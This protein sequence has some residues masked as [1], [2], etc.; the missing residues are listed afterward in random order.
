MTQGLGDGPIEERYV[1]QMK[2]VSRGLDE[3]FNG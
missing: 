2:A 3:F 1:E